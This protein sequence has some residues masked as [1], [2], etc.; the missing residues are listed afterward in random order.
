METKTKQSIEEAAKQLLIWKVKGK[1]KYPHP[2][3]EAELCGK[4]IQYLVD[5]GYIIQ[6]GETPK[7]LDYHVTLEGIE[8]VYDVE[9][10]IHTNL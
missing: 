2:F 10:E 7:C 4:A 5:K 3:R 1:G 6:T 9:K 8:H